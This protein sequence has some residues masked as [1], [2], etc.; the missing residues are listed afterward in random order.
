MQKI[1]C[2]PAII[3]MVMA[4]SCATLS[5]SLNDQSERSEFESLRLNPGLE[6]NELRIDL[7]RESTENQVNDSTVEEVDSDYHPLGFDLGNRLFY[8]LNDNLCLRL[9]HLL[10]VSGL[11]CW[12]VEQT[13]RRWQRWPDRIYTYCHDS[14]TVNHP[15]GRREHYVNH[16]ITKDGTTTVMWRNRQLYSVDIDENSAVYR[17]KKRKLDVIRKSDENHYTLNKGIWKDHFRLEDKRIELARDYIIELTDDRR[18]LRINRPGWFGYR[19]IL[20]LEKSR[21]NL[22][23][24]YP[25]SQ[26]RRIEFLDHGIAVYRNRTFM[27]GWTLH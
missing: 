25:R 14:L 5:R 3:L 22:Y 7:I 1:S 21:E 2:L 26:D 9:D 11:D 12:S 23:L 24:Y 27:E 4:S 10:G 13:N 20:T 17:Y 18:Q 19:V 8:D 15:P 6:I 16:S